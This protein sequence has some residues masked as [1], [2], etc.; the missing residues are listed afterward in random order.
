[1][2]LE[3]LVSS[4]T[5]FAEGIN[6]YRN[7][8]KYV[9]A[10]FCRSI[11]A[12]AFT[13]ASSNLSCPATSKISFAVHPAK[14]PGEAERRKPCCGKTMA[15][16]YASMRRI[17]KFGSIAKAACLRQALLAKCRSGGLRRKAKWPPLKRKP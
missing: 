11:A 15:V 3:T 16:A 6:L 10:Y 17:L 8:W 14:M 12:G 13:A 4:Q 2:F 9:R 7:Y 1:M 5:P